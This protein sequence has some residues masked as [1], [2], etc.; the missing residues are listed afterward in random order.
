MK[1][2]AEFFKKPHPHSRVKSDIV[3]KYLPA[4]MTILGPHCDELTYLDLFSGRGKYLDDSPST[5]LKVLDAVGDNPQFHH[6]LKMHFYESDTDMYEQLRSNVE[7]HPTSALLRS[8]PD[9]Q[10]REVNR[11]LIGELPIKEGTFTFIDPCGYH[12]L[13]EELLAAV[14]KRWGSD[15]LFFLST[16]GIKR[17]IVDGN[18]DHHL[19]EL[20]GTHGL[21]VLKQK[22]K[23]PGKNTAKDKQIL[24]ALKTNLTRDRSVYMIRFAMEFEDRRLTSHHLVFVCKHHRGFALMKDVMAKYSLVDTFGIPLWLYSNLRSEESGQNRLGLDDQMQQ[25]KGK[26]LRDFGGET[27]AAKAL[28]DRCHQSKYLYTEKNIKAAIDK[29]EIDGKLT[30]DKPRDKRIVGGQVTLGKDRLITFAG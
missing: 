23:L 16:S 18:Q 17:N 13:T 5:P 9:V 8:K 27:V 19:V 26:L 24:D 11:E 6:K 28:V 4:W 29:L 3:A 21:A 2:A 12:N 20:F 1:T 22:L 25:L 7:A 10:L 15:C 14:I 30:V